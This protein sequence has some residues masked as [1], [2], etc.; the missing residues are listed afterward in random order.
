MFFTSGSPLT[1]NV[2]SGITGVPHKCYKFVSLRGG[3]DAFD[4]LPDNYIYPF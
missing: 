3:V 1:M 2:I 4:T